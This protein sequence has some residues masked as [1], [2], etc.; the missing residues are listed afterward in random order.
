MTVE[1]FD[2][3]LARLSDGE[4]T[5]DDFMTALDVEASAVSK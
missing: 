3:L 5:V 4:I 1:P 2:T